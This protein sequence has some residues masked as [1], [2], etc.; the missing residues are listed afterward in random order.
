MVYQRL[1]II[2]DFLY[3]QLYQ[4]NEVILISVIIQDI[5]VK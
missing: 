1:F 5:E 3:V 2:Y 4:F